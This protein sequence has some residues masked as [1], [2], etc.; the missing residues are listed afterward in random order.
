MP[1]SWRKLGA[2]RAL[3]FSRH[4]RVCGDSWLVVGEIKPHAVQKAG[5]RHLRAKSNVLR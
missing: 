2:V 1:S 5:K 4:G 3:F